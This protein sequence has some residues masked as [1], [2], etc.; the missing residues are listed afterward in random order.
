MALFALDH[1]YP[2]V[3]IDAART[4]LPHVEL[5]YLDEIDERLPDFEDDWRILLAL[6][7]HER[8]WDGMI[9]NNASMLNQSTELAVLAYTQLTLVAP[10]AVGHDPVRSTGLV[11]A[12]IENIANRTTPAR[13]QVWRLAGRTPQGQ[14]PYVHLERLANRAGIDSH[15]LRKEAAPDRSVLE[16]NP[17]AA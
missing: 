1:N 10:V 3:F 9:T 13:P 17:L 8:S 6:H 12:H 4:Y 2:A 7:H 11:L 5:V 16:A 15:D 14:H